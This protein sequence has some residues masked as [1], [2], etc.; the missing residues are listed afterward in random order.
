VEVSSIDS[1]VRY[2]A[3]IRLHKED[4][5]YRREELT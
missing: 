2:E 3:G 5:R 1:C 4:R